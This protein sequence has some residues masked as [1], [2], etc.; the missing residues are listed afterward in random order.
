MTSNKAVIG[1]VESRVQAESI[2]D[3]LRYSGFSTNDVS[4]LLPDKQGTRD[5]AH[6]KNTKAPEGAVA[7][8]GAGGIV[9]GTLGLVAGIGA[10]AIPLLL[11]E[12]QESR[13]VQY[14]VRRPFECFMKLHALAHGA[15][16]RSRP[17]VVPFGP[18]IFTLCGLLVS[19][20]N[21]AVAVWRVS[22]GQSDS[23][24]DHAASGRVSGLSLGVGQGQ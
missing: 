22:G 16:E 6:E 3:E 8:V 19:A 4:V 11:D 1:L 10:L 18:K 24:V 14:D 9:G 17:I 7:G 5:F 12:L 23:P 13:V 21:S 20:S 2:L 15:V